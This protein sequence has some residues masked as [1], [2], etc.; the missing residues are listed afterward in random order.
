M[1]NFNLSP[2]YS[3]IDNID[4]SS[5]LNFN[6]K[7]YS[8]N[9]SSELSL[10]ENSSALTDNRNVDNNID[11]AINIV[12]GNNHNI[13]DILL[14]TNNVYIEINNSEMN[15][16]FNH[17]NLLGRKKKGSGSAGEHNEYSEDNMI[18]K[19]KIYNIDTFITKINSELKK[20]P[21]FIENNGKKYKA[22]KLKKINY[23]FA[24]NITINEIRNFLNNKLKTILSVDISNLYKNY[25]K[26]YNQLVIKKLYEEN[27][28]NVT[29]ILE[30]TGLECIKYS[31]KDEDAF[32]NEENSCLNGIE[33]DMKTFL[34]I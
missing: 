27:K 2:I 10:I 9:L 23:D 3:S 18:R 14:R 22:N 26:N 17:Y 32:F 33:K 30:K 4:L 13:D 16:N 1:F 28:T 19:F 25:P 5:E 11:N 34:N 15:S 24:K 21:V 31:R 20:T 29:C 8:P 12:F 6:G 7:N